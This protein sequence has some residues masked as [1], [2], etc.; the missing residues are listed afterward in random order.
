[1]CDHDHDV[2][3]RAG[4]TV[5]QPEPGT[6]IWHSPLGGTYVTRGEFLLPELPDPARAEPD[7]GPWPDPGPVRTPRTLDGPILGRPSPPSPAPS[8]TPT[9][10]DPDESP[11]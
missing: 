11:F 7:P 10:E 1:V 6:F 9:I 3:H 4:W 2:K 5:T 8:D